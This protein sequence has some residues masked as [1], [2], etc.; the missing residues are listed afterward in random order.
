MWHYLWQRWISLRFPLPLNV[1]LRMLGADEV[2][3]GCCAL[4][5]RHKDSHRRS[6]GRVPRT[7]NFQQGDGQN[8]DATHE[9]VSSVLPNPWDRAVSEP[10]DKECD[11]IL[12]CFSSSCVFRHATVNTVAQVRLK[13][14]TLH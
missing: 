6:S 3:K 9:G 1:A 14:L 11:P 7:N 12:P 10:V 8:R 2:N 4:I 5:F 13:G